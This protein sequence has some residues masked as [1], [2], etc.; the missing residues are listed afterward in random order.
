MSSMRSLAR[1]TWLAVFAG[2]MAAELLGATVARADPLWPGGPDIPGVPALIPGPATEPGPPMDPDQPGAPVPPPP[3]PPWF[4]GPPAPVTA[5]CSEAAR[6]CMRLSTNEAWLMDNGRVTFGPTPIS[7][8]RP[9]YE[10]PP[11][12]F[13]VAFKKEYHWSTMHNA[14]MRYAI[15]FNGDIATHI[16][17]IEEQ[18]HGCIRMT[19]DGA[20]AFFDYLNPGDIIE[21]VP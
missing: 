12:V 20:Q 13:P 4:A 17:P 9:G 7:H 5:P 14:E 8:G 18:S 10:T 16:G 19:P 15:F 2:A 21:V 11:G 1:L 6:G 3:P